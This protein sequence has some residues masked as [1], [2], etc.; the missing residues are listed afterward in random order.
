MATHVRDSPAGANVNGL[1]ANASIP[2]TR[3]V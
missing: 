3:T 2:D 1:S